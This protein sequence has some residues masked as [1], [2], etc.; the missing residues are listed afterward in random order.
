[1]LVDKNLEC[2]PRPVDYYD[3]CNIRAKT[4]INLEEGWFEAFHN[5]CGEEHRWCEKMDR[6]YVHL[7]QSD[8]WAPPPK[9]VY[10]FLRAARYSEGPV[11]FHCLHGVDRTG[12]MRAAYRILI[13]GWPR[14]KAINEMIDLGFHMFPYKFWIKS[15]ETLK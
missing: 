15:L 14:E 3:F 12:Y 7:P 2:G 8:L 1:M 9:Q 5:R 10:A 11:Y 6:N 4:F 13:Q